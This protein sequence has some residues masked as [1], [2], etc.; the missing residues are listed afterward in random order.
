MRYCLAPMAGYTDLP[1]RRVCRSLGLYYGTTALI[2]SGAL[3][4]GNPDSV[5]ILHRGDDEP[6]LQVQLL[7]SIPEDVRKATIL[8]RNH[9]AHYEQLDFNMGCPV[10]KVLKRHA[11]AALMRYPELA[12][13]CVKIMRDIWN[14]PLTV[15]T[16]ILSEDDPEPTI[17]LCQR[18]QSVG[19]NGLT[20]HGRTAA[21][22]YSG[23][24]HTGI[25][26]AVRESLS[27]PVTANGGIFTL[28]DAQRLSRE[29]GCES[30]MV[31]RGCLSNPW[32]FKT[33]STGTEYIAS[34]SEVLETLKW[35]IAMMVE[36][37]GEQSAMILGRKIVSEYLHGRGFHHSIRAQV[38]TLCTWQ[39]FIDFLEILKKASVL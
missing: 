7:G 29:S 17:E 13:E 8:L 28:E 24:V 39:E 2:D 14:G 3:V 35:H 36:E 5:C 34:R 16:R 20:I 23:A 15:K 32:I 1:F 11:G 37:Y 12:L 4:H 31:A 10:R 27:I 33:L 6:W 19:I 18:L 25:I 26:S 21:M 30:I 9:P 22:I 38:V